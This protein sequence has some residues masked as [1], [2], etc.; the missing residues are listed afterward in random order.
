MLSP[1]ARQL[2]YATAALYAVLG[3]VLFLLPN[4]AS[5]RFAWN[6]SPFVAMTLGGW[7]LGNG[8]AAYVV[9]RRWRFSL[10]AS[11]LTYL[12]LF[13]VLETGV[14]TANCGWGDDGS[15]LYITADKSL[16]RVKTT[17]KGK[18]F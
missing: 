16:C 3:L 4:W 14:A 5:P 1:L 18:G 15:V 11:G 7:C 12:A 8:F 10:V 17:T 2:T 9:V 13:G 6:V